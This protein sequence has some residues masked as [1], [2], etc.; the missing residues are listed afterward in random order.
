MMILAIKDGRRREAWASL[1]LA[2]AG[3][4]GWPFALAVPVLVLGG[5]YAATWISGLAE[6]KAPVIIG[7]GKLILV[8]FLG[9]GI[10]MFFAMGEELGWRGYMLPRLKGIGAFKA[11]LVVGFLHGVWH[12]PIMFATPWYHSIGDKF[13]VAPLFLVTLTLAG[14]LFGYLRFTTDRVWPCAVAHATWNVVLDVLAGLTA[15]SSRETL[16][17]LAGESGVLPMLGLSLVVAW[18]MSARHAHAKWIGS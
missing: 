10:S 17:Y 18:I 2:K 16:E 6:F 11:M 5:A 1:G 14:I 7:S 15:S 8:A 9:V 4:S 13:I 12:L 3:L